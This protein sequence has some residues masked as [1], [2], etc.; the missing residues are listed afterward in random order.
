MMWMAVKV[1]MVMMTCRMVTVEKMW[2]D[3]WRVVVVVVLVLP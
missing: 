3:W 1:M 2:M